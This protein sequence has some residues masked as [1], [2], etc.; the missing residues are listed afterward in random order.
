MKIKFQ[1]ICYIDI[2]KYDMSANDTTL[3]PITI[4]ESK[5]L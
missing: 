2:R 3:H 4:C 5:P 1:E